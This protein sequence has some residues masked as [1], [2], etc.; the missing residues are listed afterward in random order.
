MRR[1]EDMITDKIC[2]LANLILQKKVHPDIKL[3]QVTQLTED[4]IIKLKEESSIQGIILDVDETLRKNM[5]MIPKCNQEWIDIVKK[6]LKIIVVSNG[7]D[8]KVGQFFEERNIDYITMAFKPLKS[9]FKKACKKME[10]NPEN[11]LVVGDDLF[12][13]IYGGKRMKMKTAL[14]QDVVE[15]E[16]EEK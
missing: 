7:S 14:V 4:E 6:H 11:V 2:D 5:Q 8:T 10:V 1:I 13:D 12:D 3:S 15:C 9:G 16:E